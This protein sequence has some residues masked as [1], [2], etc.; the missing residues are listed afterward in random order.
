MKPYIL[1]IFII[2]SCTLFANTPDKQENANS[3]LTGEIYAD[4]IGIKGE[5]FYNK[6][7]TNSQIGLS[8]GET[9]FNKKLKYN[10][11][12]DELIY[13][14]ETINQQVKLD[15]PLI[16]SFTIKN[17]QGEEKEFV[18]LNVNQE[19]FF[20]EVAVKGNL[21]LYI[22]HKTKIENNDVNIDGSNYRQQTIVP[23]VIYYITT[24]ENQYFEIDKISKKS[25]LKIFPDKKDQLLRILKSHNLKLKREEDLVQF[26]EILNEQL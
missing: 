22:Q 19:S 16:K 3:Y 26:I 12:L 4:K 6:E 9:V 2:Y 17:K 24:K 23:Q 15:K 21:N 20:A 8:T 18:K 14:N 1:L 10:Y 11:M 13:F 5:Q 7:W 25:I